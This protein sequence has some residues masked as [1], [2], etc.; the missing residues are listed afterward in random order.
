M[1]THCQGTIK[2]PKGLPVLYDYQ[3]AFMN[4][5]KLWLAHMLACAMTLVICR[6]SA[7]LSA[8]VT[9]MCIIVDKAVIV[10][11]ISLRHLTFFLLIA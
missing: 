6:S 9:L 3:F 5:R 10:F 8:Y 4:S 2:L 1:S 7:Q 11:S